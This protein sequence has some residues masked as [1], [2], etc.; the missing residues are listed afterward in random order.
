MRGTEK[1]RNCSQVK[2]AKYM[3]QPNA[4]GGPIP[5]SEGRDWLRSQ[6]EIHVSVCSQ[7]LY[8]C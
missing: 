4:L 2:E 1:L 6:A 5:G 8:K 7:V 3:W